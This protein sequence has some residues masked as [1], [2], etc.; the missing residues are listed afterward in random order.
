[1]VARKQ[2]SCCHTV[3]LWWGGITF[4]HGGWWGGIT[5]NLGGWWGGITFN[6]RGGGLWMCPTSFTSLSGTKCPGSGPA[7]LHAPLWVW[8]DGLCWSM[9][10]SEASW[11]FTEVPA[12]L[13][14]SAGQHVGTFSA[15][16]LPEGGEPSTQQRRQGPRSWYWCRTERSERP[17]LLD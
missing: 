9:R 1:M 4:N 11:S 3:T 2:T 7:P 15:E 13:K 14:A 10:F 8:C 16:S 17:S 5:F 12:D 6:H